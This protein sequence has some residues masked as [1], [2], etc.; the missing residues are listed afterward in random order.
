M[1]KIFIPLIFFSFFISFAIAQDTIPQ[2]LIIKLKKTQGDRIINS[3]PNQNNWSDISDE[4]PIPLISNLNNNK[5]INGINEQIG[6]YTLKIKDGISIEQA[7]KFLEKDNSVIY[8]EPMYIHYPLDDPQALPN[9]PSIAAQY[10]LDNIRAKEA[11]ELPGDVGKGDAN[12][13]VGIVDSGFD[14]SHQDL[15]NK[16]TNRYDIGD[17]DTDLGGDPHGTRVV[18]AAFAEVNN[19][20]GIAGVAYNCRFVPVKTSIGASS[21]IVF[22][23][24]GILYA[25]QQ[26][27]KVINIS[28][29]RKGEPSQAEEEFL[30]FIVDTYDVVLVAA[31]GNEGT[32]DYYYPAAYDNVL[33]VAATNSS[34][35][36]WGFSNYYDKIDISAP[37][38]LIATTS[39]GNVYG[40]ISGTSFAAPIVSAGVALVRTRFPSLNAQQTIARI[41][42]STDLIQANTDFPGKMGIGRLNIEKALSNRITLL[43][44]WESNTNNIAKKNIGIVL[45][46]ELENIENLSITLSTSSSYITVISNTINIGNLN[47]SEKTYQNNAFLI[48]ISPSIPENE[49]VTF[50]LSYTGTSF[51]QTDYFRSKISYNPDYLNI[52]TDSLWF[53]TGNQG[54]LTVHSPPS[55]QKL[56]L[57][58]DGFD[59]LSEAGFIIAQSDTKISSAMRGKQTGTFQ[60]SFTVNKTVSYS[61]ENSNNFQEVIGFF[62]DI[63][64]NPERVGVFITQKTY[65]WNES[66]TKKALVVEYRIENRSGADLSNVHTGIFADWDIQSSFQNKANWD[67]SRNLAYVYQTSGKYAGIKL[68]TSQEI[69]YYAFDNDGTAGSIN[70]DDGFSNTEK[71]QALNQGT[72]RNEAGVTPNNVSHVVGGKITNLADKATEIVAFALVV[73]DNLEE[74]QSQADAITNKFQEKHTGPLPNLSTLGV[75]KGSDILINPSNTHLFNIY[76]KLPASPSTLINTATAFKVQ[77]IQTTQRFYVSNK[78]SLYESETVEVI[79]QPIGYQT[80]FTKT[81]DTLNILIENEVRFESTNQESVAWEWSFGDGQTS[82]LENPTHQFTQTGLYLIK[83][84]STNAQGCQNKIEQILFVTNDPNLLP[85]VTSL[86]NPFSQEIKIYPNPAQEFFQISIPKKMLNTKLYIWNIKGELIYNE[87]LINTDMKI[88]ISTWQSGNY[89]I[90]FEKDK[91]YF[92]KLLIVE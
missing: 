33:G 10:Y 71:Y 65:A 16:H 51:T 48:E 24:N 72:I 69:I 88:N 26:G 89:I 42:S 81:P 36:R 44:T 30:N 49:M 90:S 21:A 27:C 41:K 1:R 64:G 61:S 53:T 37:G 29:G 28:W 82:T 39:D 14:L 86:E 45:R 12:T 38:D 56:G 23:Y 25:A 13:L 35:T 70:I 73:G 66:N 5:N 20:I 63:T 40:N 78:D 4:M 9:D 54:L 8:A 58:Y 91:D 3:I 62:E 84:K 50:Q 6:F 75:C 55:T 11:W 68:L 83:L 46:N 77:D 52:T 67:A 7:S 57:A 92:S 17:N 31:G 85:P 22:G 15:T 87:K 18:G 60:Q 80:N 74:L 79:L 76:Q 59:L 34:D 32:E 43:D 19:S 47:S 2:V